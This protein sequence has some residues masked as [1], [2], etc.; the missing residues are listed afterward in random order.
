M[1]ANGR[2]DGGFIRKPWSLQTWSCSVKKC[3]FA[4]NFQWRKTCY[5]CGAPRPAA[6]GVVAAKPPAGAWAN[7]PPKLRGGGVG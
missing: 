2:G 6:P 1:G 5:C 4:N 3:Q 7:G